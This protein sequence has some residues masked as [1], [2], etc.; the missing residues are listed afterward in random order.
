MEDQHRE[1]LVK[2]RVFMCSE[3]SL[4]TGLFAKL[5]ESDVITDEHV[6][7]L[8][9]IK[10]NDTTKAAV[11]EFLSEVL[12]KRG[13]EAF[14]LFLKALCESE[15]R[16]VAERLKKWLSDDCSEDADTFER[17]QD[18]LRTH[19]DDKLKFIYTMPWLPTEG[20]SLKETF[21]QRRLRLTSGDRGQD[22]VGGAIKEH[23]LP[24][25]CGIPPRQLEELLQEKNVLLIIDAFDE[26]S[27]ENKMLHELIEGKRLKH[28]PLLVTSRPNFLENKQRHFESTFTVEGYNYREQLEHVERYAAHKNIA[29]APFESMLEEESII[30]LCSNPLN[31]TLLCLL[32]EEDTQLRITRTA[33]YTSIHRIIR[34]KAG[35][36]MDLTEAEVEESLLRPLY[37]FAFEAHQKNETVVREKDSKKVKNFQRICEVGYLTNE[38]IISRLQKEVRFQFTHKTFVEFLTAK[39]I[40]E[41]DREERM[42][43]MQH[44]RYANCHIEIK[45]LAIEDGFNVQQNEAILGFLF[46][47]LEEESA[48][49]TEMASLV[50]KETRFSYEHPPISLYSPCG[51]SHQLLRLLAEL[52]VVPPELADAICKRRPSLIN[53]HLN[54]SVSCRRGMLKLCNLRFQP[55]I[56]LNVYLRDS[57]DEEEKMSFVQK[58]IKSKS[59]DC[60]KIWIKPRDNT[61]LWNDVRG[62]RIGQTDSFQQVSIYCDYIEG[63]P[64]E[65]FSFGNHLSELE[66]FRFNPSCSFLLKAALHKPLTSLQLIHCDELDD[67]C[68]SLI[69]QLLRNQRNLQRVQLTSPWQQQQHFGF[70]LADFAQMENLQSLEIS[71]IDSTDEEMRSLEAILKRNKLSELTIDSEYYSG[72]LESVLNEGFNSMSSLRELRLRRVNIIHLTNLRHLDLINFSLLRS[73][74]LN[75]DGI[76]V[77]SD[78][79]RT[80]RNLQ[81]LRID[82]YVSVA[83]C[84]LRK[85][86]EAIAGCH[87]LQ[88]L[89][90]TW[91]EMADSVVP[92]VCKMIESLK[93]LTEFTLYF[94][95]DKSL[96]EEGFKQL[97]PIIKRNG[98]NTFVRS[99]LI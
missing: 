70:F 1:C 98:L 57:L 87:R 17:L 46:G 18:E 94:Q 48:E 43:W 78:A 56:R 29:S 63:I 86:F 27:T 6:E 19:Y 4:S 67:R 42:N 5:T 16:H 39:H 21:V 81:H 23:L 97:E 85:L 54:C 51:A 91:L 69:R 2:N 26:A 7:K 77:L 53:I 11:F 80:W 68:I 13:P 8:Q 38:V 9:N 62:F 33:L 12:P 15:Q 65:E 37:Q 14:D 32:R 64:F 60:S 34:R 49:L 22:S 89:R 50:I 75:D 36:R 84:S 59:I 35:E 41:M 92:S 55:P 61:E 79:L 76:A 90:F 3:I 99:A 93:Q 88:I 45:G 72:S 58:L 10:K 20:F 24:I 28:K 71:L 47:L 96:T 83:E 95:R 44:L 52:N 66:L 25:D 30:D 73:S 40:A 31:L 74:E 82:F